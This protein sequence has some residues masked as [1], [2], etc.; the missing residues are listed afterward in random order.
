M[1]SDLTPSD[2]PEAISIPV[3][4]LG[5]INITP[6]SSSIR[7]KK[8]HVELLRKLRNQ[9]LRGSDTNDVCDFLGGDVIMEK[10]EEESFVL[11]HNQQRRTSLAG[12][13]TKNP[14]TSLT[15]YHNA[16]ILPDYPIPKTSILPSMARRS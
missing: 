5:N 16:G 11:N 10:G 8:Y 2:P 14:Q 7:C 6:C 13:K 3:T 1:G 15:P 12:T 9:I 4:S